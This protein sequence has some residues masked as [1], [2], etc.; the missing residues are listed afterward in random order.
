MRLML[1]ISAAAVD[2]ANGGVW[3][4]NV[5]LFLL[6][7]YLFLAYSHGIFRTDILKNTDFG[8]AGNGQNHIEK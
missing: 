4:G 2:K 1:G 7:R 8:L 5:S 6:N 3:C